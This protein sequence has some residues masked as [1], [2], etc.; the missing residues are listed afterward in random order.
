MCIFHQIWK[1]A[2]AYK[3][4]NSS[5]KK[6]D[7]ILWCGVQSQFTWSKENNINRGMYGEDKAEDVQV[8]GDQSI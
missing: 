1:K 5:L 3:L 6:D 4:Y 8:R 7:Y 2:K